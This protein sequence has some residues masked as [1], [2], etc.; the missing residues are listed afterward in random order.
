MFYTSPQNS[1]F[2]HLFWS[3]IIF[4][5]HEMKAKLLMW[6]LSPILWLYFLWKILTFNPSFSPPW[7]SLASEYNTRLCSSYFCPHHFWCASVMLSIV[8]TVRLEETWLIDCWACCLF[9]LTALSALSVLIYSVHWGPPQTLSADA[10]QYTTNCDQVA[11][12][13]ITWSDS[14]RNLTLNHNALTS[15]PL[16]SCPVLSCPLLSSPCSSPFLS[17]SSILTLEYSDSCAISFRAGTTLPYPA[18]VTGALP[19]QL[20]FLQGS[21]KKVPPATQLMRVK[22]PGSHSAVKREKR[23]STSLFPL[24]ANRELHKLHALAGMPPSICSVSFRSDHFFL[25]MQLP[26]ISLLCNTS[27]T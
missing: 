19:L 2:V 9:P 6:P 17:M 3:L 12:L 23:F 13:R 26:D 18:P 21:N 22:Q 24:S 11:S 5:P 8:S 20:L 1:V 25:Q 4:Y 15:S 14:E 7:L 10:V 16:F 27:F